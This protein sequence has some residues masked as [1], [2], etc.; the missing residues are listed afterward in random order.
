MQSCERVFLFHI[1]NTYVSRGFSLSLMYFSVDSCRPRLAIFFFYFSYSSILFVYSVWFGRFFAFQL[2][3]IV[4]KALSNYIF[5]CW[6]FYVLPTTKD[7]LR[8]SLDGLNFVITFSIIFRCVLWIFV[9]QQPTQ[10]GVYSSFC[11]FVHGSHTPS[12]PLQFF[13][14]LLS[15]TFACMHQCIGWTIRPNYWIDQANATKLVAD[16]YL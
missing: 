1:H 14:L 10:S 4:W 6:L 2:Y 9:N 7:H 13:L 15:H 3:G 16:I 5:I 12:I 8:F 11:C